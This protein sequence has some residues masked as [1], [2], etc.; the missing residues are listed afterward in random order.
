MDNSFLKLALELA[1]TKSVDGRHGPFGALIVKDDKIIATGWN[2][3]VASCDPTA[4]AEVMAI[5]QASEK[6]ATHDLSGCTVYTSCEPCPMCL[7]A[8]YWARIDRIVFAAGQQD[9]AGA[10]FD[11]AFLYEEM[12]KTWMTRKILSIQE[13]EDEGKAVFEMWKNNPHKVAY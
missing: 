11:D 12:G 4:H 13:L 7:A 1:M 2:Q 10:G 5:R 3:V 9:A 6:L 8:I